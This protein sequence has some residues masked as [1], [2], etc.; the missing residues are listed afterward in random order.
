[1]EKENT[2]DAETKVHS[3]WKD[4]GN[5]PQESRTNQYNMMNMLAGFLQACEQ[6]GHLTHPEADQLF[7]DL[8]DG[9]K[10]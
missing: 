3:F 6:L 7:H 1:M 5:F 2:T 4:L 10:P 8:T 9:E